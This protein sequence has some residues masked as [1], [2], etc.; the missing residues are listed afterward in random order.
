VPP[1]EPDTSVR[2]EALISRIHPAKG[3]FIDAH[4]D[5]YGIKPLCAGSADYANHRRLLERIGNIPPA[6]AKEL[7]HPMLDDAS[8]AA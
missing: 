8:M 3:A 6:Q 5:E 7:Y 4:R 1:P 2:R